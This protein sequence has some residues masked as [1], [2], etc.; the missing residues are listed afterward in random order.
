MKQE[1]AGATEELRRAF[2][3]SAITV[4]ED[5]QG[6]AYVFVENVDIGVRFAPSITWMGGHITALYPYADIYPVFMGAAVQ[7]ADGQGFEAPVTP[8]HTF[9]GRPAIQ[10]S[11]LN[12]Q[13][14]NCPQTAVVKFMKI[15]N[16]LENLP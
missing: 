16:F 8:G 5:G 7:R 13:V 2:Q 11:R 9:A 1:V 15:L 4:S 10:I 14:Q 12:N 6:G 3:C